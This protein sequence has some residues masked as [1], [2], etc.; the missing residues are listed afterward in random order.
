MTSIASE[1]NS[2]FNAL[3]WL[4]APA[5]WTSIPRVED[6]SGIHLA[7]GQVIA[8]IYNCSSYHSVAFEVALAQRAPCSGKS[9]S[10]ERPVS[11]QREDS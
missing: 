2:R 7:V 6:V 11:R 3:T 8:A 1:F 4:L 5:K 10:A 9:H